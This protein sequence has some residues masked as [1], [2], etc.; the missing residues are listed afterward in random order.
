MKFVTTKASILVAS[1][2]LFFFGFIEQERIQTYQHKI[3][4]TVSGK[5]ITATM[6][7]SKASMDFIS[8]LPLDLLLEDF[9]STEKIGYLP[10][11]LTTESAPKDRIPFVGDVAYHAPW[12][13]LA[14]FYKGIPTQGNDLYFLGK[15]DTGKEN[16]Q[17]SVPVMAKIELVTDPKR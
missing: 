3:K 2:S 17:F 1:I 6:F 13:N 12:S 9:A 5:E 16:L 7:D 15:I 4:I 10:K 8:L 11:R 14:L